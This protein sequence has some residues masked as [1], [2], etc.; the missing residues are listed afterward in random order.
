MTVTGHLPALGSATPSAGAHETVFGTPSRPTESNRTTP[1]PQRTR[2]QTVKG[3]R[4]GSRTPFVI[5]DSDASLRPVSS[6]PYD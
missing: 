5:P 2:P 4:R 3:V 6:T 1:W